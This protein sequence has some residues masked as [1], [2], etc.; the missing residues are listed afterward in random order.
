VV[1]QRLVPRPGYGMIAAFEVLIAN[2]A[3]RNLL[4]DGKT[5][6]LRNVITTAQQEGMITLETSLARLVR[7]GAISYDAAL[8]V[9]MHPR[10]LARAVDPALV[11]TG[12]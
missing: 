1:A 11:H 7:S 4:R 9:S 2:P 12:N 6:Q 3:V 5:N 8:A 10:D